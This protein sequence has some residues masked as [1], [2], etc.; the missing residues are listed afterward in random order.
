ML[1]GLLG[2]LLA[3]ALALNLWATYK[4][5]GDRLSEPGQRYAQLALIWCLPFIGALL[6]V[7]LLRQNLEPSTGRYPNE[8][9]MGDDFGYLNPLRLGSGRRGRETETDTVRDQAE[10]SHVND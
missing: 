4:V 5:W 8:P 7:Y 9:D 1:A 2:V 6:V 3:A 10:A